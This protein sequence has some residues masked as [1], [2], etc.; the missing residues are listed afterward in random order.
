[1]ARTSDT[2]R[3]TTW[4]GPDGAATWVMWNKVTYEIE[5]V[6]GINPSD[7][8]WEINYI[9]KDR[10]DQ[11]TMVADMAETTISIPIGQRK[12]LPIDGEFCKSP[13]LD[14]FSVA[15]A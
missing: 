12:M 3:V 2:R 15:L 1:M 5:A 13:D 4:W 6:A 8:A 7:V 14:G 11:F 9:W 10:T